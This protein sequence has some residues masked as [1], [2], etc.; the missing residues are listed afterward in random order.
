MVRED[1]VK[2]MLYFDLSLQ[3]YFRYH[4]EII[5]SAHAQ[6][7]ME[8]RAISE[9]EIRLMLESP[10][11][12]GIKWDTNVTMRLRSNGHLLIVIYRKDE[13]THHIITVIDTS[14]V[15]KYL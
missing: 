11:K 12:E 8:E 6:H 14:K 13:K 1:Y 5:F 9:D 4:V 2:D 15:H 7:R 3:G 10:Q